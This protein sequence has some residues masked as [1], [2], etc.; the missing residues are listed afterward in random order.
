LRRR[1]I[2][3]KGNSVKSWMQLVQ[4]GAHYKLGLDPI[5]NALNVV[6]GATLP[7]LSDPKHKFQSTPGR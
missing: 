4:I 2:P 1:E 7:I 3:A 6:K 5:L